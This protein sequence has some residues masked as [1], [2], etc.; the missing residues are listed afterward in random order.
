VVLRVAGLRLAV[1]VLRLA[2]L[3]LRVVVVVAIAVPFR[4]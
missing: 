1:V 3:R 4:W 2:G